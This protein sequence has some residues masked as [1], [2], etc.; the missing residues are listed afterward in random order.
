[1]KTIEQLTME[2]ALKE[3][4]K[5]VEEMKQ[6]KKEVV[7]DPKVVAYQQ[8]VYTLVSISIYR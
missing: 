3:R 1:M 6:S 2:V 5:R 4:E 7:V 8:K